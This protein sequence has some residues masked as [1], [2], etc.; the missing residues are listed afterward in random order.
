MDK[1]IEH[2][3][4]SISSLMGRL[5]ELELQREELLTR[6]TEQS[7]LVQSVAT[8]IQMIRDM[9]A[10]QES[11]L[12]SRTRSGLNIIYQNLQ[13]ESLK[14]EAELQAIRA[15]KELLMGQLTKNKDKLEKLNRIE[16]ELIQLQNE[17]DVDRQS[18]RLYL[19][20]FEESRISNAMDKKKMA[21]VSL[22]ERARP[23]LIPV[24]PKVM[25]RMMLAVFLGLNGGL[26]LAFVMEYLNDS[27][28]LPHKVEECLQ[29]PV[30]ASIPEMKREV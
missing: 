21:N 24:S 20:K 26:G 4:D 30:L 11:K 6:Y 10:E 3:P 16:A 19:T 9:L 27:L 2:N 22:I 28:E 29:L 25:L 18:Y 7:P 13:E 12:H 17:V 5:I 15:K 23:P 1:E 8:E 14:N